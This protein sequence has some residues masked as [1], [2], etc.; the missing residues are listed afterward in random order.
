MI[1]K[2]D[3]YYPVIL[4]AKEKFISLLNKTKYLKSFK[5]KNE[6]L[7][8][9]I[10]M[11]VYYN[12]GIWTSSYI[13]NFYTNYAQSIDIENYNIQFKP[14]SFLHVLT[15]GNVTGGHTRVVER[16][17]SNAPNSQT[18]SVVFLNPNK[19]NLSL[20]KNN[21][22]E[23]NGE[24]IY[25]EKS[26][27][28]EQKALKLRELAL[29]YEYVILHTHME[30]VIP[31]IAFGTPKFTR[32]VLLYNHASHMFWIGK[33]IADLVL[34]IK[35]DDDV[36]KIKKNINNTF[37]LG[38]PSKE[39]IYSRPDKNEI[40][41]K[42]GLPTDKKIIISSGTEQKYYV[43]G[44]DNYAKIIQKII[45]EDTYCYII[46]VKKNSEFWKKIE[47]KSKGHII[48]LGYINFNEGYMDYLSAADLYI[49]SYPVTGYATMIDAISRGVPSLSLKT[50]DSQLDYLSSTDS[51]CQTQEEFVS[52]AKRILNDS[53]YAE[54]IL[55]KLQKSLEQYQSI[56]A[57]NKRIDE[58]IKICPKTHSV[59]DLSNEKDYSQIDDLSVLINIMTDKHAFDGKSVLKMIE[60]QNYSD[61]SKYGI[62]Y[63]ERGIPYI[64]EVWSYKKSNVK[65][66]VIKIFGFNTIVY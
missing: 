57:W 10:E 15:M 39:I 35:K 65:T 50:V 61:F 14:N 40:R 3:K 64:F 16:W 38:V 1:T 62:K 6:G 33:S 47:F 23:K 59:K 36:T 29:N 5:E 27:S 56:D 24:C 66:K 19:D 17:I 31:S 46:G 42:L 58:L 7:L 25:F 43:I 18:H 21:T 11:A 30:D 41:K 2:Y 34:D 13:E 49:D 52:K 53:V 48:P 22:K 4:K 44:N 28:I 45:D 26:L 37:F 8:S 54:I 51:Y 20:L 55:N 63:R 12:V 60:K 32:P 9:L